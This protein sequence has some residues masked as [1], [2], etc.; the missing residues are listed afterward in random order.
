MIQR[1]TLVKVKKDFI[2]CPKIDTFK[3]HIA[4]KRKY[5]YPDVQSDMGL[6][7]G[8]GFFKVLMSV[9]PK[10]QWLCLEVKRNSKVFYILQTLDFYRVLHC[11][12]NAA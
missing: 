2:F 11:F 4:R 6:D 10:K 9:Q 3:S 8:G 5:T 7:G 12:M 1:K